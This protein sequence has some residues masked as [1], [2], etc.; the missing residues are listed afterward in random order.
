MTLSV[1]KLRDNFSANTYNC[2]CYPGTRKFDLK[3]KEWNLRTSFKPIYTYN[4]SPKISIEFKTLKEY[5]F[6]EYF[7]T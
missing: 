4:S 3:L 2:S 6:I 1:F 7:H 5:E